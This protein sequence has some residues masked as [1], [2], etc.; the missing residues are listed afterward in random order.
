MDLNGAHW[1]MF[2]ARVEDDRLVGVGPFERD[3]FPSDLIRGMP[4]AVHAP[5]RVRAPAVRRGW[6]DGDRERR[7]GDSYVE[8]SWDTA[9]SLIEA[10]L[11]RVTTQHGNEAIFAGSY[12]WG[13]AGR[14]HHAST[15]LK[16]FL[17]TIGGFVDQVQTYSYAAGQIICPHVTGDNRILFGGVSTTWPAILANA[18]LIVFF[19]G[20]NLHNAKIAAGGLGRHATAGW[21][22]E[23]RQRGIRMLSVGPVRE[24]SQGCDWLPLR[25]GT[26]TA[27]MLGIAHT[28]VEEGS[29]D[30][31]FLERY[32][33]GYEHFEAYVTGR[34][35][36]CP[37][38]ADWAAQ[39]TGVDAD[40]IRTLARD[41]ARS[42]TFLTGSWSLQR[43]DA[44]EQP[45]WAMI[46]LAAMLGQVGLPG[47]GVG[48]GYGSMGNRGEPRPHVSSPSMSA[49][50]NPLGRRIPVARAADMLRSPGAEIPFNGETIRYP[51]ARIVWW[52]GGNPMHHHQDLNRLLRAFKM[53]ETIIVNEIWWTAMAKQAD[54]V[55]PACTTLER[56]DIS[57]SPTDRFVV[58]MKKQ[59]SPVGEAKP[60]FE[61]FRALA[62]RM[63]TLEPFTEGLD[64]MGWIR[65]LYEEFRSRAR[66]AQVE[67]PDFEKFW[68]RGYVELP[69][70]PF[71]YTLFS[72]FRADPDAHRLKT[73]SG[74]I[75]I[76][77]DRIASFG[78]ADTPS[79]PTWIEPHEWL[80]NA[81]D[82][83][84]LH[85]VSSQP[86]SRLHSQLDGVGV[87]RDTKRNDREPA[88]MHPDDAR[89]RGIADG[90]IVELF[91][92]RGRCLAVAVPSVDVMPGVI[93]LPTGAW[94]DPAEPGVPGS[95]EVHGNP[96]VLTP[97]G[98][99]SSLS[100]APAHHST[101]VRVR[102]HEGPVPP[103]RAFEVPRFDD[104]KDLDVT[105]R[106]RL[107]IE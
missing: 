81:A 65:R 2:R 64:E 29:V 15:Q 45:L 24:V 89:A 27:L 101:L 68:E 14:F 44:G 72:E 77:S 18:E 12:G 104:R 36:A 59:I 35:D 70:E 97:N 26:D 38:S 107:G 52:A 7:G 33:H 92:E 9:L 53:P 84:Q 63:G 55:L 90:D 95:L 83:D 100:Q 71:E 13:S 19:G 96:N 85:L 88:F 58:A 4:E 31:A 16:R 30:R 34:D 99:T 39:I 8:V 103:V 61:I 23:A 87:S 79:H 43:Q 5:H 91:N 32:T 51:H 60:E 17:N 86:P 98:P 20:I 25:P 57:G 69:D 11:R 41:T 80:G 75:E 74:K 21:I 10:E 93:Q 56:N 102:R 66:N 49:G 62:A 1:G 37:K 40:R 82:A 28:L 42:R 76:H 106:R 54:I 46:A 3:A 73:P 50:R 22:G 6:L 94:Y 105:D 78:Y 47:R 67:L 48:F